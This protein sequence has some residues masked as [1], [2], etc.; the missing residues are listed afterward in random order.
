MITT[1]Y[2]CRIKESRIAASLN[3]PNVIPIYDMGSHEDLLYLARISAQEDRG[4]VQANS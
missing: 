4:N 1:N 3:H 2:S